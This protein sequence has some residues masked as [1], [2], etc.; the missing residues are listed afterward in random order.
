MSQYFPPPSFD[1]QH[2]YAPPWPMRLPHVAGT[3]NQHGA[4]MYAM[5]NHPMGI[6]SFAPLPFGAT[7][8][9]QLP[10]LGLPTT[11]VP[12]PNLPQ[13]SG[14]D[15][16]SMPPYVGFH[17]SL[18]APADSAHLTRQMAYTQPSQRVESQ[19]RPQSNNLSKNPPP[20]S[21]G[22]TDRE[23]GEVSDG[24]GYDLSHQHNGSRSKTST[25]LPI[26]Q[27]RSISGGRAAFATDKGSLQSQS[28]SISIPEGNGC[29]GI[30]RGL[31]ERDMSR[32]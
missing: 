9:T 28:F 22:D 4:N 26:H 7:A 6:G 14:S 3:P 1:G 18:G 13:Q 19:S 15:Q 5:G 31:E 24:S 12:S 30:I 17:T 25:S 16:V 21:E 27:E 10:G 8:P 20:S 29:N 2:N 23:E 32:M 11:A